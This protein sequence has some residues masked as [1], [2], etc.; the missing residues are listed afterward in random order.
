M[1]PFARRRG[2][3]VLNAT[4]ARRMHLTMQ[5]RGCKLTKLTPI[6]EVEG[7]IGGET[8]YEARQRGIT[9]FQG[10]LHQ[11]QWGLQ[12]IYVRATWVACRGTEG[13]EPT[14]A[15]G[16]KKNT[17]VKKTTQSRKDGSTRDKQCDMMKIIKVTCRNKVYLAGF[18]VWFFFQTW[19]LFSFLCVIVWKKI[20]VVSVGVFLD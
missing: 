7:V 4:F 1:K 14:D 10:S 17:R 12:T 20:E 19:A 8:G 6:Q 2:A 5:C 18:F 16:D 13:T 11:Q 3:A 15:H 9:V